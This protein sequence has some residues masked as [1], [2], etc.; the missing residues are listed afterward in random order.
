MTKVNKPANIIN[1]TLV[2]ILNKK[3]EDMKSEKLQRLVR[4]L[5]AIR[6]KTDPE[7]EKRA[8]E[9][10]CQIAKGIPKRILEKALE[11][12]EKIRDLIDPRDTSQHP[13]LL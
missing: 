3:G 7:S 13:L 8:R 1:S 6:K 4:E 5:E 2:H 11:H 10:S 12:P 9:L